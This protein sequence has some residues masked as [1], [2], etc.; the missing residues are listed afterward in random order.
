MRTLLL[1]GFC[2]SP[3]AATAQDAE[4]PVPSIQDLDFMIGEWEI[5]NTIYYHHEPDRL[6]FVEQGTKTCEYDLSLNGENRYIL[7]RGEWTVTEGSQQVGRRRETLTA[8]SYNRFLGSLEEIGVYS[9]WPSHGANR[10]S[11]DA[12]S[13][14]VTI[15]GELMLAN[16]IVERLQTVL[17]YNDD[18]TAYTSINVANFSDLPITQF[19]R[20]FEGQGKKCV[21]TQSAH[22]YPVRFVKIQ[23]KTRAGERGFLQFQSRRAALRLT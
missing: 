18:F 20:V 13:S 9:N 22:H 21:R 15:E 16:H 7:C 4:K 8:I 14:T 3:L 17:S 11:L 1:I 6:L 12:E 2:L 23:Q 10:V 19:N 5:E